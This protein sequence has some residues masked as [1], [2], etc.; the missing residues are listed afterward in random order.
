M[1]NDALSFG[2]KLFYATGAITTNSYDAVRLFMFNKDLQKKY[3][4]NDPYEL[5]RNGKWTFD[6]LN[7]MAVAASDDLNGDTAMG[8]EDQ[9]GIAW[10]T[11]IGGTI[12]YY[13]SGESI[14]TMD[15]D[16]HPVVSIGS[17]RST[18]IYDKIKKLLSDK[19][20]YYL[21][22]DAD[23]L[24]IFQEGR[25]L[26]MTE[27]LEVV[28]RLRPFDVNFGL[29]PSPKYEESQEKYIQYV[30]GWCISP[31]VVPVNSTNPDR[32]G[33]IIQAIAEASAKFLTSPYYDIALTGK[34]LR[35]NESSEMLDI[36]VNNFVL[37][38]CDLYQWSGIWT[39]VQNGM[40]NGDELASI[41]AAN[42]SALESAIAKTVSSIG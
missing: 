29:L 19:N 18:E 8:L 20:T 39:K 40:A 12:F 41:I 21:G 31:I 6:A 38:N 34:A 35:D 14:T 22:A 30:D 2:N 10:Q 15:K 28:N 42:K 5:V 26:F 33:F 37:E 4:L 3:K 9:W 32:T 13:A 1:F 27:V 36:V 11:S 25:S 7:S 24:T 23:I 17:E 16:E